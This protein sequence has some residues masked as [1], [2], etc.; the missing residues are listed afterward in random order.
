MHRPFIIAVG[1]VLPQYEAWAYPDK[2]VAKPEHP[3]Y[4]W[5]PHLTPLL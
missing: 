4:V 3:P 5:E 2:P 1:A